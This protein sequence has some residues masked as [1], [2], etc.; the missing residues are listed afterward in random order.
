MMGFK[1]HKKRTLF[2]N[3]WE[4]ENRNFTVEKNTRKTRGVEEERK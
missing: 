1:K 2:K 4:E 3:S